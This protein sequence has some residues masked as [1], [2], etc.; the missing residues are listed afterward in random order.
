MREIEVAGQVYRIEKLDAIQQFHVGRRLTPA[1]M[2]LA[3]IASREDAGKPISVEE[4]GLI[5]FK[6]ITEA[7]A[8]MSND[9]SEYIVRTSLSV[10][11]RKEEKSWS[12]VQAPNGKLMYADIELMQMMQLVFAVVQE[13]LGNFMDAL[14]TLK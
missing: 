6:P 12:K 2:G 5:F 7:I 14:P 4:R 10:V 13:N 11:S 8:A 9:D 1:L 3:A